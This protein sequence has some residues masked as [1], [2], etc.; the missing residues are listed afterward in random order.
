MIGY[1]ESSVR[2]NQVGSI[3][4]CNVVRT[5]ETEES[6][7]LEIVRGMQEDQKN[8]NMMLEEMRLR[9]VNNASRTDKESS[10]RCWIHEFDGH[11]I[12]ECGK[13]KSLNSVEIGN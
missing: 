12:N 10:K 9:F 5:D 6:K 2:N 8:T 13:F 4:A 11:D 3:F 1:S 7:L